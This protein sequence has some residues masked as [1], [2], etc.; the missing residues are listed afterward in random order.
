MVIKRGSN[1][2]KSVGN[3]SVY[4]KLTLGNTEPRLTKVVSTGPTP[5]WDESFSWSFESPPK[6]QKLR[7]SCKNKSKVG[8]KSYGKVTILID[9]V[10]VLGAV[11]GEYTLLPESKSGSSRKLEIEFQWS[12]QTS[13][14]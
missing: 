8:K 5:E 7:I 1:I 12:N 9:Q 6:G 10:V 14:V 11:A 13:S 4:C 3:P 2:K